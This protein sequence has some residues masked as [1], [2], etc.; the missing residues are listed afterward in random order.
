MR[1]LAH[2][3]KSRVHGSAGASAGAGD[4]GVQAPELLGV[5]DDDVQA[6][7]AIGRQA[8][9]GLEQ[10]RRSAVGDPRAELGARGDAPQRWRARELRVGVFDPAVEVQ[11]DVR[12]A[13][14]EVPRRQAMGV[15]GLGRTQ[16]EQAVER[17]LA[18]HAPQPA[19]HLLEL[20]LGH[21]QGFALHIGDEIGGVR[22]R[23]RE[24][25]VEDPVPE[26]EAHRHRR[27]GRAA[28]PCAGEHGRVAHGAD[29]TAR[30]PDEA[31][32]GA[33]PGTDQ[34]MAENDTYKIVELAGT[35]PDGVTEAMR[36]GVERAS[37]TLRNVDWIEVTGIRGHVEGGEIAH[38]QVTMKVGF[39]LES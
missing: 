34:G 26:R 16:A 9:V 31:W 28:E 13:A 37:A 11:R 20:A 4:A 21:G 32:A 12:P 7:A 36:S 38:F 10:P 6:P 24:H 27:G 17:V 1:A 14:G 22:L 3:S 35:S 19:E 2:A 5:L 30:W 15:V 25:D 33:V 39:K 8:A 29:P 23:L 18:D